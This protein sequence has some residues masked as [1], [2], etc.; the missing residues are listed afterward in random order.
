MK[1]RVKTTGKKSTKSGGQPIIILSLI[2][3][4]THNHLASLV[5]ECPWRVTYIKYECT[6]AHV[7]QCNGRLHDGRRDGKENTKGFLLS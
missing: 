6:H 3:E 5:Y 1:T 2:A 4:K 7:S